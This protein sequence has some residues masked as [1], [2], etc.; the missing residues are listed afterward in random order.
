MKYLIFLLLIIAILIT[1]LYYNTQLLK[2]K[3]QLI[4]ISGRYNKIKDKKNA[5]NL[6]QTNLS[7]KFTKPKYLSGM[8]PRNTNIYISPLFSSNIIRKTNINMEITFLDCAEVFGE[9]WYYVNLP[10]DNFINSR[11]W[12]TSKDIS[13]IY[14]DSSYVSKN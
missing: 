7:I 10:V 4:I 1:H 14:S 12:I 2:L 13:M 8:I 3:K 5:S 11:G 9:T 6:N